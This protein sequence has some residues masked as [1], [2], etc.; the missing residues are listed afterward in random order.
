MPCY[1][2]ISTHSLGRVWVHD[3]ASKLD[4]A[5]R[6][7]FDVE[8]F[9]EDV[10]YIADTMPMETNDSRL[11]AAAK[12]VRS[13]CDHRGIAIVCLQP[14]MH[15]EGLLDRHRHQERIDEMRLWIE[16][17][18]ILRTDVIAIPSTFLSR[19]QTT[20]NID[21]IVSDLRKVADLGSPHDIRFAYESLAWGT[22]V[23][24][25]EAC[26]EVVRQVDRP[27]FGICLDTYNI[28]GRTY[29]DPSADSGKNPNADEEMRASLQR[30][31][32][33]LDV[34][35]IV[36]VQVVD[37]ERLARPLREGHEYYDATQP[38]RMSWSRNCRL[39]YGEGERGAYLPIK[40][41]LHTIL[42][43]LGFEGCL[44]AEL[45]S[46]TL[47]DVGA[48]VPREHADRAAASWTKLV[49]DFG[50]E[51]EAKRTD[52]PVQE[53]IRQI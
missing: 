43:E 4:E 29:A 20:G 52:T 27:N 2:A 19:D 8:L 44:G 45:F 14:F 15:Y 11:R 18:K 3:L 22:Y 33:S 9:Y 50:L 17:A 5:A 40:D 38:A 21:T 32:S 28:A 42:V 1:P 26:W 16:L 51:E 25:W 53:M 41:I 31:A 48:E 47:V 7:G 46:R 34:E 6:I 36:W 49:Q 35:K 37:A 23:D 10:S 13:M 24:T 39:F 30:M 12:E